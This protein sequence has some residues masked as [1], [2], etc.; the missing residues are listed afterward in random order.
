MA[1]GHQVANLSGHS[2]R[3]WDAVFS[4][5]GHTLAGASS[6]HS[7]DLWDAQSFR[8]K[9]RLI[10]HSHEVWSIAFLPD[11]RLISGGKDHMIKMWNQSSNTVTKI[12]REDSGNSYLGYYV[13]SEKATLSAVGKAAANRI[14]IRDWPSG[15]L[16][17]VLTNVHYPLAFTARDQLLTT[18]NTNYVVGQWDWV[19]HRLQ[20][21]VTLTPLGAP[22]FNWCY[23]PESHQLATVTR[24]GRI[25]VWNLTDASLVGTSEAHR[26][27]VNKLTFSPNG[28]FLA[29]AGLDGLAQVFD[30]KTLAMHAVIRSHQDSITDV[31][32]SPDGSVLLT[33]SD[34]GPARLWQVGTWR[35]IATLRGHKEGVGN[36]AFST[37]GRTIATCGEGELKLWH[38][39][40][41]RELAT[42]KCEKELFFMR[43]APDGRTLF[44]ETWRG[45]TIIWTAPSLTELDACYATAKSDPESTV[46]A[47]N[48]DR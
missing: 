22:P 42:I 43:F 27:Q 19:A 39:A 18:L 40:T 4:P 23:Q 9:G 17:A 33:A 6:D 8:H 44:E 48:Y 20:K 5:D 29:A 41:R 35:E 26:G 45:T 30:V 34:D 7:I 11:N 47:D 12:I 10:G 3:I 46:P 32:F 1:T 14:D 31:D 36:A 37:D 24:A 21:Q 38:V 16:K 28:Q 2:A 13:F 15:Q 25:S